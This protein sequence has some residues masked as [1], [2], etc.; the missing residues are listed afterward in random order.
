MSKVLL[1]V[2]ENLIIKVREGN[3][4]FWFYEWL[5]SG[6]LDASL[7]VVLDPNLLINE[8]WVANSWDVQLLESLIGDDMANVIRA[9]VPCHRRGG[10]IRIWKPSIDGHFSMASAW[11]LVRL[12]GPKLEGMDWVWHTLLPKK[13]SVFMWKAKFNCLPVDARIQEVGVPLAS[14][15]S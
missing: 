4:S 5:S 1:E 11:E 15:C 13:A 12:K 10:D 8:V 6:P 14:R 7:G 3:I 2:L 9:I